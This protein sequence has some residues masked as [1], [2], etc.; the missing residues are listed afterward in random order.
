[1]NYV[2]W[3][4]VLAAYIAV[5]GIFISFRQ[6]L[7]V[8][9]EKVENQELIDQVLFQKEMSRF[10]IRVA[11]I[12]TIPII[13]IVA[14]FMLLESVNRGLSLYDIILQLGLILIV[15]FFGVVN[16]FR[17]RGRIVSLANI[18]GATKGFVNTL[19]FIGLGLIAA[20]PIISI[21]ALSLMTA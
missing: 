11:L 19:V 20:I 16:V 9:E 8:I 5:I 13:L 15:F 17:I 2:G 1:M 10:F 18:D 4:F 3:L 6:M 7:Q 21:V 14:G 12:E